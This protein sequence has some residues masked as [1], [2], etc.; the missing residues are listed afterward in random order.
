MT[1]SPSRITVGLANV[2]VLLSVCSRLEAAAPEKVT[3]TEHVAPVI[4]HN[5]SSCHRPGQG[6]PFSLLDYRD[7][8]KRGSLI[9]NV[10]ES[11]Y[12]PPWPPAKGWGHFSGERRLTDD[13]IALISKWVDSGM[14][15]GPKDKLPPLPTFPA[16]GWSLGEPDLIIKLPEAFEVPADGPDIYRGF[17]FPLNLTEDKWVTA[18][19]IQPSARSVVHHALYFLDNSGRAMELEKADPKP[20]FRGMGIPRTGALGGWAVGATPKVLPMGLAYALP[21]GS[22]FVVQVHFHPSGKPQREQTTYG[23]YFAKKKP[24]KR[25][26]GT[27]T[28]LAF[29]IATKLKTEGIKAG[30]AKFSINGVWEVPFDIDLVNIGGHAHYLCTT[31]KTVA[32]LPS[33]RQ[34]KLFAID[35]W[36]FNWQ[37]RYNYESPV[38]LPKGTRV[39]SVLTYDN[40]SDNPR[41]PSN[42][43]VDVAWGEGSTDEM[44]SVTLTFVAVN[45]ADVDA[46]RGPSLFVKGDG[47]AGGIGARNR[48]RARGARQGLGG[49]GEGGR[50]AMLNPDLLL[51]RFDAF[52]KNHDGKVDKDE[53][54]EQF[55]NLINRLDV[56]RDDAITK[57]EIRDGFRVMRAQL[58][59]EPDDADKADAA[60]PAAAVEPAAKTSSTDE[61][62]QSIQDL[63]GRVWKPLSPSGKTKANVLVF[64]TGDCPVSNTFSP[65]I[66]RLSREYAGKGVQFLL[67]EVDPDTTP[68][69]AAAHAKEYSLDLPVLLD[70]SHALIKRT[71]AKTTPEA[72]VITPDG[73]VVYSGRIDDRFGKLGRQRP[74]PSQRELK[75]ALDAVLGGKPVA[76]ART[77][78]VGCPIADLAN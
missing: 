75:D 37:G 47:F 30:D 23:I 43:P 17:A 9:Q 70:R 29:G 20:G 56:N 58:V 16:G 4:F 62:A 51:G 59:G 24:E 28:P 26:L 71:G 6:T 57:Q 3:F 73:R 7:V 72:A 18:V 8:R 53:L 48:P 19:D 61:A 21:K 11:N 40:S 41:N 13:Q 35:D 60:K 64:M 67:V 49:G 74:E 33:G 78:A 46:Y 36:D 65:E 42:P 63:D 32:T 15:E 12:M 38:R 76:V 1:A 54:P 50:L 55:Q 5:C 52:D 39:K 44:G 77:E 10:T 66:V 25:V 34:E 68:E 2:L 45:E 27:Q 69:Q 31:M 22:D 14:E